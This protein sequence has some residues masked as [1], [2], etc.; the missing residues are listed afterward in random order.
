M[1][2]GQQENTTY[3]NEDY[4]FSIDYPVN[5]TPREYNLPP[6]TVVVFYGPQ[7]QE[8]IIIIQSF[9]GPQGMNIQ[10]II[11]ETGYKFK[12]DENTRLIESGN[13]TVTAVGIPAH[14]DIYYSSNLFKQGKVKEVM[15]VINNPTINATD[16]YSINYVADPGYFNTT[17]I[18]K[19]L[20]T[21]KM[22][23]E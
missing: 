20:E 3:T 22:G 8:I 6:N 1:V 17:Q 16:I 15:A 5:W 10:E 19:M 18:D 9:T 11:I 7:S 12:G 14:Y 23:N 4:A 2:L 13:T 21:L